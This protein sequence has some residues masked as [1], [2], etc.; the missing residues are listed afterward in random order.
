[1][2]AKSLDLSV[3]CC[4]KDDKARYVKAKQEREVIKIIRRIIRGVGLAVTFEIR[5][6]WVLGSNFV[7]GAGYP[8]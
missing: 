1:V 6:Q 2:S 7:R 3:H 4:R 5:V 8:D